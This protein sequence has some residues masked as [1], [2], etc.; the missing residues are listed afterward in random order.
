MTQPT[1][2]TLQQLH[3]DDDTNIE[4]DDNDTERHYR[5]CYAEF[6]EA[7]YIPSQQTIEEVDN[8]NS[9]RRPFTIRY[10]ANA[11]S[12]AS[13]SGLTRHRFSI[14]KLALTQ[15]WIT[16]FLTLQ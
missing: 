11:P 7:E 5:A 14:A 13:L 12:T 8:N 6:N 4:I 9:Q 3:D 2:I 16:T 1:L 10:I 15:L